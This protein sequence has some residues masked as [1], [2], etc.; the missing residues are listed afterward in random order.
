MTLTKK[1]IA[2]CVSFGLVPLLVVTALVLVAEKSL[3]KNVETSFASYAD[4]FGEKID[5]ILYERYGDV[6]AFVLNPA[7]TDRTR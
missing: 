7:V 4:S 3:E 1:L 5:R 6:Q 2:T